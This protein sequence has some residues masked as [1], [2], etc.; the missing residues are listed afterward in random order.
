MDNLDKIINESFHGLYDLIE[1]RELADW[2][3]DLVK[4]IVLEREIQTVDKCIE[5]I[6][7]ID[8]FDPIYESIK[9]L[10]EY[11]NQIK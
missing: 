10:V 7:P 3:K 1:D 6:K 2:Y 4:T 5:L 9:A 8:S 11:K